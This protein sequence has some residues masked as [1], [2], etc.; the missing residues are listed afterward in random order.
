MSISE[1]NGC[2]DCHKV[3]IAKRSKEHW[4]SLTERQTEGSATNRGG[5]DKQECFRFLEFLVIVRINIVWLGNLI[6][7]CVESSDSHRQV[8]H[9]PAMI[10]HV[11]LCFSSKKPKDL[12][13]KPER[14]IECVCKEVYIVIISLGEWANLIR[15]QH[16]CFG[17]SKEF[18]LANWSIR[19]ISCAYLT[20]RNPRKFIGNLLGLH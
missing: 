3:C 19:K 1:F 9:I 6:S 2:F 5:S 16:G 17:Q 10:L 4:K 12:Y 14:N 15:Y 8:V 20:K 11:D 13:W 7:V 18:I